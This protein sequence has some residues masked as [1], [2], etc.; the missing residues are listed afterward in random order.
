MP[1]TGVSEA[2]QRVST[3]TTCD[4]GSFRAGVDPALI[5]ASTGAAIC[6]VDLED[7]VVQI[8]PAAAGLLRLPEDEVIGQRLHQLVHGSRPGA[9]T[10]CPHECPLDVP[11]RDRALPRHREGW[12]LHTAA[13]VPGTRSGCQRP[14]SSKRMP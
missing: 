9:T 2:G 13:V 8:N 4:R 11:M 14:N 5:L 3:D 6:A 7:R 12:S 1:E 10:H